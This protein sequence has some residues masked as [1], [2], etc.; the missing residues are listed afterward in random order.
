ML[1]RVSKPRPWLVRRT[2]QLASYRVFSVSALE[3][4]RD[5]EEQPQTFYRIESPDWVNVIAL[6]GSDEIVMIRQFRHGAGKET[7]EIPGGLVDE[8]ED[9]AAAAGRELLEETGYLASTLEPLGDVSPNP[10]LFGNRLHS[11]LAGGCVK[12]SEIQNDAHEETVVEL[13][14]LREIPDRIAAGRIDHALV[15]AA[16]H[17]LR[18]RG[19]QP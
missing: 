17:W 5:Q 16:F 18:L 7:L 2:E 11:F 10:A 12:V 4:R 19:L 13:V 15:M 14:P 6:T 9:P 8:G 1:R 3:S